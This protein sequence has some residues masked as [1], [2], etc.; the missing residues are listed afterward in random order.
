MDE[1][2][3]A[4]DS[5]EPEVW[6]AFTDLF[7]A[8]SLVFL[9]LVAVLIA[10]QSGSGG[11]G[12]GGNPAVRREI[13]EALDEVSAGGRTFKVQSSGANISL[14]L[15]E[16]LTFGTGRF[17][18][19][20]LPAAGV[21]AIRR[22]GRVLADTSVRSF[23]QTIYVIGHTDQVPLSAGSA[24]AL[25]SDNLEL[26]ARR[27]VTVS[28]LLLDESGLD[29]CRIWATG[30]GSHFPVAV[31]VANEPIPANRRVEIVIAPRISG[32]DKDSVARC[33]PRGDGPPPSGG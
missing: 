16:S 33:L 19:S 22:V 2:S 31:P 30:V 20:G 15:P 1:E 5:R 28:R 12:P 11:N 29:P 32:V 27:A 3:G 4:S 13:L 6:P 8:L 26:S 10:L 24:S 23:Y 7:S 14:V 21:S 17:D 9:V 25:Y 18:S